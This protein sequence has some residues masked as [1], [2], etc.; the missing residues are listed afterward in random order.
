LFDA[1]RQKRLEDLYFAEFHPHWP[2]LHRHTYQHTSQ[3]SCLV[4]AVHAVGLWLVKSAEAKN[5]AALLHEKLF[6]LAQNKLLAIERGDQPRAPRSDLLATFQALMLLAI[7]SLYMG[8]DAFP[9]LVIITKNIMGLCAN[10]GAF[11]QQKI[12]AENTDAITQ[13]Q[14]QRFVK[15]SLVQFKMLVHINSLL[16]SHFPQFRLFEINPQILNVRIPSPLK[17]WDESDQNLSVEKEQPILVRSLFSENST[18]L[19]YQ[20]LARITAWDFTTG[21]ILWSFL[22]RHPG[23]TLIITTRRAAPFLFGHCQRPCFI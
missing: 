18:P 21:M 12:D 6:I 23:E 4:E 2:I 22:K 16:V 13:E 11:D 7:L 3:P 5:E 15:L 9:S 8:L 1:A 20:G 14:Y 19:T 17:A 10:A